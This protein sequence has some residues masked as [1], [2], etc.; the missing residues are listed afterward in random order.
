[1]SKQKRED[2]LKDIAT[3]RNYVIDVLATAILKADGRT[4]QV[5]V[6]N[7][8]LRDQEAALYDV[9]EKR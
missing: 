8:V 3:I 6:M 2:A 4:A 5:D 1:M 9:I 7:N